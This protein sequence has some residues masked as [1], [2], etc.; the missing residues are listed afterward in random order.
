MRILIVG[1]GRS[2]IASAR[3]FA[4]ETRYLY[5]DDATC[6]QKKEVVQLCE[7]GCR[8]VPGRSLERLI[9]I[10]HKV[11]LSPSVAKTHP[12][13]CLARRYG[14]PVHSELE[15]GL[16]GYADVIAVTGTNGKTTV[17]TLLQQILSKAFSK[18]VPLVGNVGIPASTLCGRG[19]DGPV[20]CE[21]SSF[22][23]EQ[24]TGFRPHVAVLL[25]LAPDHLNWHRSEESYYRAKMRLF[26]YQT[27]QDYAVWN[28]DDARLAAMNRP[29]ADLFWFSTQNP[30]RGCYV[31]GEDIL[32]QNLE[33]KQRICSV[34]D[35]G[36][37]P[38]HRLENILACITVAKLYDVP[39][40][41]IV[42]GIK[43]FSFLPHR[44]Q[45]CG[46]TGRFEFIDDSKATNVHATLGALSS[47]SAPLCC[48]LGGAD[49]GE[50]FRP[51]LAELKRR[52]FF[53]VFQGQTRL[54]LKAAAEEIGFMDYSEA[55]DLSQA[56]D[57]AVQ[58]IPC[59]TILLSPACASFD[60]FLDFAQRGDCFQQMVA[61]Y[62]DETKK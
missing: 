50:D 56:F 15:E 1:L 25:N 39:N 33:E 24:S 11:I 8:V 55:R 29:A 14:I 23:A 10:V 12:V 53:A 27:P 62:C 20:V 28:A 4:K 36:P 6:Y 42:E 7:E 9:P 43:Q 34:R 26:F 57:L 60:A 19:K 21:V 30:C 5:D 47:F 49:K 13:V 16:N 61:E 44:T 59:G 32:F 3:F 38:K 54:T 51:L 22:Q 46:K 52:G 31:E 18:S 41:C 40:E 17:C 35:F 45:Q 48:I 2:G 58:S 37:Q